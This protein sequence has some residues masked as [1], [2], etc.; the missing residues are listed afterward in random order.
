MTP[1]ET[2][3]SRSKA[4]LEFLVK[5]HGGAIFQSENAR[6]DIIVVADKGK[7]P[8]LHGIGG[9]L[10][11][12]LIKVASLKARATHDI[13]RSRWLLDSVAIGFILPIEPRCDSSVQC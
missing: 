9:C 4:D 7:E 5:Q 3:V 12:E 11:I 13:L 1:T 10:L 2:P 8:G 6:K